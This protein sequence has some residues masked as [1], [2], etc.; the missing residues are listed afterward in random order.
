MQEHCAIKRWDLLKNKLNNV[1]PEHFSTFLDQHPNV[2]VIDC[3]KPEEFESI[4]M[5]GAINLDY[6]GAGFWDDIERL[7]I[8]GT[9]LVYCNSCRR[10]TRACMLMQN[11][12]FQNVYNLDGGL[13]AWIQVRGDNELLRQHSPI[14][15]RV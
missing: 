5:P 10:S 4:H 15:T 1:H 11:G 7:P 9:Y 2:V 8:T 13:K 12:G 6:L 3:R 14:N